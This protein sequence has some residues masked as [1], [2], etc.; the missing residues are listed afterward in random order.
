MKRN[1]LFHGVLLSALVFSCSSDD[2]STTAADTTSRTA[3]GTVEATSIDE[4]GLTGA[5]NVELPD[6]LSDSSTSL[7]LLQT[8]SKSVEACLMRSSAKQMIQQVEMASSML[9]HIEA[10]GETIQWNTPTI[11]DFSQMEAG[12]GLTLAKTDRGFELVQAPGEDP[13]SESDM[14]MPVIGIYTDDTDGNNVHVYLC[15]GETEET[16][17][18]TQSFT[19]KGSKKVDVN[20]TQ[21]NASAGVIHINMSDDTMGTFKAKMS[22]DSN[23]KTA[24]D[25]RFEM[26]MKIAFS[27]EFKFRQ[28]FSIT[29]A[30]GITTIAMSDAGSMSFGADSFTFSS[31]GAGRFDASNGNVIFKYDGGGGDPFST[32]ACVDSTGVI[33]ACSSDAKFAEGGSL[34]ILPSVVPGVF[35][36]TYEP[37]APSGFDCATA[38]WTKVAPASDEATIAA[39]TACDEGLASSAGTDGASACFGTGYDDGGEPMDISFEEDD[40]STIGADEF[41]EEEAALTI[42]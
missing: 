5:L 42:Y 21:V 24:G 20:G 3:T 10:E 7:A 25:S 16:L 39:H 37:D 19:V 18:L 28:K 15:E 8:G 22:Y 23:Y 12:A 36:D 40:G 17:S 38:T 33:V 13:G 2:E 4:L 41:F 31:A 9:C 14:T 34:H 26:G 27:E 29:E 32:R 1:K 35:A 6:S 30:S 11:L